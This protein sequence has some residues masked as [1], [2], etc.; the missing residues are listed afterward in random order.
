MKVLILSLFAFAIG[1]IYLLLPGAN[2]LRGLIPFRPDI[3]LSIESH[4]Y[5]MCERLRYIVFAWIILELSDKYRKELA[6]FFWLNVGFFLDYVL[7]YN[8]TLFYIVWLPVSYSLIMGVIMTL[9]IIKTIVYDRH[10][11]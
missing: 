3:Q 11:F 1:Y 5:Y 4:V 2:V 10:I 9:T 7:Y 8:G 6:L